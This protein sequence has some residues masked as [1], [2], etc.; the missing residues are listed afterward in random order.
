[1]LWKETM[2]AR[3][4]WRQ[5]RRRRAFERAE[6]EC[7][8][9]CA[10]AQRSLRLGGEIQQP[11]GIREQALAVGR[12]DQ[13]PIAAYEERGARSRLELLHPG[14]DVRLD[15]VESRCGLRDTTVLGDSLEDLQRA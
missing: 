4:D 11:V 6:N 13:P 8:R 7:S 1:N 3:E 9:W 10:V 15:T 12:E 2:I 14:G 5:S